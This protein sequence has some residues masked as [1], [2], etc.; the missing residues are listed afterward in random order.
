MFGLGKTTS[1]TQPS[2]FDIRIK[3]TYKNL[4]IVRGSHYDSPSVIVN[5]DIVFSLPSE[6]TV[7]RIGLRLTGRYKLD[8]LEVLSQDNTTVS[9]PVK[10]EKIVFDIVWDNLLLSPDG[11]I[12][13]GCSSSE[14]SP[15][16]STQST[17][18]SIAARRLIR[19]NSP[20]QL[21]LP[22]KGVSGTP[23]QNLSTPNGTSFN[24]PGGN[25]ELPFRC[26]L[27]GDVPETVEGLLAGSILYKFEALIDR[28]SFK[29]PWTK[30]RY[31]R[32]LRTLSSDN[33]SL[34]ET[35]SIGKSW[36]NKVQY[37]VSIPSRA[38]PIGGVTPINILL[39]PLCKGM[40]LGRIRAQ[41]IQY[42]AFKGA[43]GEVYDDEQIVLD[44]TMEQMENTLLDDKISIDS[45]IKVP[46]NLK[47]VTQ[48]CDFKDDM[49]KVRHKLKL[50]INL[51]NAGGHISELRANL[52]ITLFISPNVEMTGRTIV[53][54]KHGKIHFRREEEKLFDSNGVVMQRHDALMNRDSAAPPNYEEHVFD[55]MV[56]TDL[57][58]EGANDDYNLTRPT[59]AEHTGTRRIISVSADVPSYHEAVESTNPVEELTPAYN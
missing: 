5:G 13:K 45:Y 31:F 29:T 12:V 42:Y 53:M 3:S 58:N 57:Q 1:S 54:D 8:F 18:P 10:E 20:M 40:K 7:K 39:V 25:Y 32:I 19:T 17:G 23:F 9:N 41:L 34:S 2:Y 56:F 6:V 52:P 47:K 46:S 15:T 51:M 14:E 35:I 33:F 50:Q 22:E 4:V 36:P 59:P 11:I 24:L 37:E 16:P 44:C 43:A 28:G 27:P 49:I 21:Q 30:Y 48:D 26:I 55:K 38:V